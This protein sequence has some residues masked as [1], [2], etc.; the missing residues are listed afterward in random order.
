MSWNKLVIEGMLRGRK[1]VLR[2]KQLSDAADD[3]AWA[4]DTELAQLNAALLPNIPFSEYL[5]NYEELLRCSQKQSSILAIETPEGKHIGNCTYYDVDR[6]RRSAK[7]GIMLGDRAYWERGYGV[8]VITT[9]VRHIF[10]TT[11][12]N[13]ITVET[14]DWNAR[15][16]RCFEKSGFKVS[17]YTAR[18]G[19]TFVIMEVKRADP[20]P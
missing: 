1:A 4:S 7:L 19:N 8:D 6:W 9:L 18:N 10:R 3:Y 16:Q 2:E 20:L 11:N 13:K 12:L 14:L 17:G 5:D 15:A